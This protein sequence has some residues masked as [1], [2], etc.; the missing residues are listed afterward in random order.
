MDFAPIGLKKNKVA[1]CGERVKST[2]P[3][4]PASRSVT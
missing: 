2:S 4:I 3:L 1:A